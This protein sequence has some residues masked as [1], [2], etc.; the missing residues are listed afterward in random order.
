MP[1]VRL[2]FEVAGS[3]GKAVTKALEL[4]YDKFQV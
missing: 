4:Q 1:Y 3:D 2:I